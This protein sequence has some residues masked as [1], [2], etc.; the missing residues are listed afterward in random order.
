VLAAILENHPATE[1]Y[2][3][4]I[5]LSL[6][7]GGVATYAA[8]QSKNHRDREKHARNLQLELTAFSP[9]I[10]PLTT[11][12][13][14]EERVRMTRRTFGQIPALDDSP[15]LGPTPLS[16]LLQRKKKEEGEE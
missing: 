10:E 14:E 4:K 7:L 12:Q 8:N 1:T 9:F 2:A 15:E 6:V 11:E 13:Q 5:A 16:L 3:G